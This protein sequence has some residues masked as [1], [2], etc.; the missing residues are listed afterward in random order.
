MASLTYE[1]NK[2]AKYKQRIRQAFA[3]SLLSSEQI[4]RLTN[5]GF[6]FK[7]SKGTLLEAAP[8]IVDVFCPDDNLG[9]DLSRLSAG[10]GKEIVLRCL[11]CGRKYITKPNYFVRKKNPLLCMSCSHRTSLARAVRCIETDE[12]F[13]SNREAARMLV[14][15]GLSTASIESTRSYLFQRMRSGKSFVYGYH[16]EYVD[17]LEETTKEVDNP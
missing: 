16:W 11:R 1:E 17:A 10:S 5:I 6:D 7:P 3:D 8:D 9:I 13:E 14:E 2:I 4:E 15:T 12:V